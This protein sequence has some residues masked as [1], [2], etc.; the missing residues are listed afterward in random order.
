[1]K[2]Y[3]E[4][5]MIHFR[6]HFRYYLGE[7]LFGKLNSSN[8]FKY[9]YPLHNIYLLNCHYLLHKNSYSG[10]TQKQI[11]E[12]VRENYVKRQTFQRYEKKK[13]YFNQYS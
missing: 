7:A 9:S 13:S 10:K 6:L 2:G 5:L 4:L 8:S 11:I 1:M 3:S 12:F